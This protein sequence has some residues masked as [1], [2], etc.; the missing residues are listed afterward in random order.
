MKIVKKNMKNY[1]YKT[2][3]YGLLS[4]LGGPSPNRP[5]DPPL[6]CNTSKYFK[7]A[8]LINE[9]KIEVPDTINTKLLTQDSSAPFPHT[10]HW[11]LG[12]RCED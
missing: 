5:L 2:F 10:P 3:F 8:I 11:A 7:G 6:H 4:N 1:Y 12:N 9:N